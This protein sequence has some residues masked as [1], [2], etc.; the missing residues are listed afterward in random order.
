M[1][2]KKLSKASTS[3]LASAREPQAS[4]PSGSNVL[5]L[6][7]FLVFSFH[8]PN[9]LPF[10]TP[11][12]T[13]PWLLVARSSRSSLLSRLAPLSSLTGRQKTRKGSPGRVVNPK[14]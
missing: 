14:S 8:I 9:L 11:R 5:A 13:V 4:E 2:A 7:S 3:L 6:L 1:N 12:S 10:Y